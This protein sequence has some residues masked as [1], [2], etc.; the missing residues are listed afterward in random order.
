MLKAAATSGDPNAVRF[1]TPDSLEDYVAAKPLKQTPVTRHE[2]LEETFFLGLRLTR[3]V[4]LGQA[5]K[6][7]GADAIEPFLDTI[8]DFQQAGLLARTGDM[9][10]LTPR[11]RLLSNEVFER[12][13]T[14]P[15]RV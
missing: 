4:D 1:S 14:S 3:G 13:I 7:F 6:A 9:I 11:G 8:H 10:R 12:F 2:A 15:E 5:T